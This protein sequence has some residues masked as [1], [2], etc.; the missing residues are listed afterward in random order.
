MYEKEIRRDFIFQGQK[1]LPHM[2]EDAIA[3]LNDP[4]APAELK[5]RQL[6]IIQHVKRLVDS[7]QPKTD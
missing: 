1:T 3:V 2:V 5:A 4:H 6:S 7:Y